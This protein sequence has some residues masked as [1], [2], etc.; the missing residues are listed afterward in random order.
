MGGE[1]VGVLGAVG[2]VKAVR[3]VGGGWR[4]WSCWGSNRTLFFF[5]LERVSLFLEERADMWVV[6]AVGMGG[7][8]RWV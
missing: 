4:G 8:G 5:I 6:K 1:R 3:A 2:A 7:L